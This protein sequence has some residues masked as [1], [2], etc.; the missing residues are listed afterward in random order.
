MY[1][2]EIDNIKRKCQLK[3]KLSMTKI[4]ILKF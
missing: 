1:L 3:I 4:N 2:V